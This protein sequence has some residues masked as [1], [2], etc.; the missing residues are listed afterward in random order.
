METDSELYCM[1][2]Q[3]GIGIGRTHNY[4]EELMNKKIE[5]ETIDKMILLLH[6]INSKLYQLIWNENYDHYFFQDGRYFLVEHREHEVWLI[7]DFFEE[8][9]MEE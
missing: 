7:D 4:K 3:I 1:K 9:E 8:K 2:C 5:K 6:K